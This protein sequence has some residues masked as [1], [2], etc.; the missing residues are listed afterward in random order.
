V[1][2]DLKVIVAVHLSIVVTFIQF[3]T[4]ICKFLYQNIHKIM[5]LN[6]VSFFINSKTF[7]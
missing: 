7:F 6:L 2:I 5:L 1:S 3:A 4:K